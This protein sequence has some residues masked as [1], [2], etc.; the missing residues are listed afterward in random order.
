MRKPRGL[1]PILLLLLLVG[2]SQQGDVYS[3]IMNNIIYDS[4]DYRLEGTVVEET[5]VYEFPSQ[6]AARCHTNSR[7]KAFNFNAD[8]RICELLDTDDRWNK[9]RKHQ[10]ESTFFKQLFYFIIL[11]ILNIG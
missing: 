9:E 8:Q 3:W 5:V 1:L 11:S 4:E 10:H 7:C 6:C 2:D